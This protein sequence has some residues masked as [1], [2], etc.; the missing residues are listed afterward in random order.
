M[1][2]T[3]RSEMRKL[4]S[5]DRVL[6]EQEAQALITEFGRDMTVAAV[7]DVL[8]D[9]RTRISA[10]Q[11]APD[12]AV[13][14]ALTRQRLE[15]IL[16]PSPH[17]VINATG[18]IIHT[19]LGRAPLS[20]AAERA[21][22]EA[23]QYSNL[24]YDLSTGE[25]GSRYVHAEALLTRLSGAEGALVVNNAA[26]AVLLVLTA[27]AWNR[28]VIISRGQLV[29]I[30]GGFRIPDVMA[31]SGA[32]LV[33][34]GTTNRTYVQDYH[35]AI[36]Q[37]SA[38]L[39]H[40]HTS[41]FRVIGFTH[42]VSLFE[43]AELAHAHD[44]LCIDDLGSGAF[45][46]TAQFGLPHEP[47]VQE[48]VTAR[49]DLCCFSGDKLLGGPQAGIIV[50]RHELIETLK[51]HP[52]TRALRV[53]KSILAG[54]QATLLHYLKGE[55]MQIPVW[56]MIATPLDELEVRSQALAAWLREH[57]VAAEVIDGSSTVGGGSLPDEKLP[58]RLVAMAVSTPQAV[59]ER[60]RKGKMP[61]VARIE[62]DQLLLDPRTVLPAQE[63]PLRQALRTVLE[64]GTLSL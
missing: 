27:F 40:V 52:L 33:E 21:M 38:A 3:A 57:A 22:I 11:A 8:G 14:V 26:A 17:P 53:S 10:G 13:I 4:P 16:S 41:N 56:R 47:T 6:Q 30:G 45:L 9:I 20:T 34:V 62:N 61:V 36:T 39:M 25:R 58:T 32:T 12:T 1:D 49:V 19:N 59:A 24:E 23:S 42:R 28:E 7:Q 15:S 5:V 31:Q 2:D 18:V 63:E 55:E 60:L 64:E 51:R 54:L 46:D 44:L 35:L 48:S 29:E 50:G 37:N 43:L